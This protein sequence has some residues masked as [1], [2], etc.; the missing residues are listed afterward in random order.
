MH[1]R[2]PQGDA[3]PL[4][5]C[6]S[7]YRPKWRGLPWPFWSLFLFPPPHQ[8]FQKCAA[9]ADKSRMRAARCAELAH[10]LVFYHVYRR[11][12]CGFVICHSDR[13]A[14]WIP[15]IDLGEPYVFA[16]ALIAC[17]AP[18]LHLAS[19]ESGIG[20]QKLF[21]GNY[22]LRKVRRNFRRKFII[23]RLDAHVHTAIIP[24][25]FRLFNELDVWPDWMRTR[26][27]ATP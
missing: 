10:R 9:F 16:M 26:V 25:V 3:K 5:H 17:V 22:L 4:K 20:A 24:Y 14:T 15:H 2:T 18:H 8:I 11:I 6:G 23:C 1:H 21:Y 27:S 13:L 19:G 12:Y 7:T